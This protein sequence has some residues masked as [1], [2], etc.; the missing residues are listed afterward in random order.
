MNV[1][2]KHWLV[3]VIFILGFFIRIR[4]LPQGNLMFSYDQARDAYTIQELLHGDIKIQGPPTS[5]RDFFHGVLYYYVSAPGYWLGRGSPIIAAVWL[6][7]INSFAIFLAYFIGLRLFKSKPLATLTSLLTAVSYEQ[8]QYA[9]YLSNPALAVLFVPVLYFGL[10]QWQNRKPHGVLLAG[11]GLGLSFQSNFIF[12]Y[13][14]LVIFVLILLKKLNLSGKIFF[15][16]LFT[17]TVTTSS[18]LVSEIKF[19]FPSRNGPANLIFNHSTYSRLNVNYLTIFD[20]ALFQFKRL[21]SLNSF[22]THPTIAMIGFIAAY[23]FTKPRADWWAIFSFGLISFAP[24]LIVGGISTPYI[25]A[26]LGLLVIIFVVYFISRVKS[27]SLKAILIFLIVLS[28]LTYIK[29]QNSQGLT[30]FA[31]QKTMTLRHELDAID[32]MYTEA[33]GEPFTFNSVTSPLYINTTWSYLFNWYGKS[34]YGYLPYWHGENQIDQPGNNL[35]L[36][37]STRQ[38]FVIIEP[39]QGIPT[40]IIDKVLDKEKYF[41]TFNHQKQFGEITVQNRTRR[42]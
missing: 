23:I 26:G 33:K 32:F 18:M 39:P 2:R 30:E 38:V 34:K 3:F 28:N 19:G 11:I 15:L 36:S 27:Q 35:S 29:K 7:F 13:H 10:W 6:S 25:H 12:I 9:I 22:P 37:L 20:S 31:I 17:V 1:L 24:A 41:S 14:S 21:I 16:L 5:T 4:Y 42:N 40:D 8:T